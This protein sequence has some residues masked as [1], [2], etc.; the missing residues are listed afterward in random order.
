MRWLWLVL[1]VVVVAG[2]LYLIASAYITERATHAMRSPIVGS[3][4]DLGLPYESVSFESAVDRIPLQGWYLPSR[5]ER[6][7][8]MLHG[9]DQN[10]W[11]EWERVP[12]KASVF[13]EHGFDVLVFDLRGHGQSGGDRLGL[14]WVERNDVRGAVDYV[15]RRGIRA[16]R[17]GLHA[18][19]YGAATALLTAAVEPAVG[20]I[21]AD[22]AFA[23]MRPLL[24]HEVQL[25]GYPPI[26]APGTALV[27]SQIY[28]LDLDQ[29]APINQV[30]KISQPVLFIH[31]GQDE[32][33][34]VENSQQLFAAAHNSADELW[35]VPAAAHVQAF[36]V[37]PEA[38]ML[39]VLGFFD[40]SLQGQ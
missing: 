19:S 11:N 34:P 13:V 4:A 30:A 12:Q 35:L 31:G 6:A 21:V 3:P 23:D 1:L 20:A 27:F 22:S 14:G 2:L 16:G 7:I 10:R 37:E 39:K 24:N 17:I 15:Q 38:Y 40:A 26:F 32:R 8:I 9:I 33:I 5:G 25:R 29:I 18:H 36:A 28:G